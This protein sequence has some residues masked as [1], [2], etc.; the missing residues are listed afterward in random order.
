MS[1]RGRYLIDR[2]KAF[3][4]PTL[5]LP[6]PPYNKEEYWEGVYHKF[7]PQDFFEW[8]NV[9]LIQDLLEFQY[10]LEAHSIH[11]TTI[12]TNTNDTI[13]TTTFAEVINVLPKEMGKKIVLLGCGNSRFGEEMAH[14]GWLGPILQLDI[15]GKAVHMLQERWQQSTSIANSQG[16]IM[17]FI[18]DDATELSAIASDSIDAVFDKG[19]LDALFCCSGVSIKD[20]VDPNIDAIMKSVHRVLKPNGGIFAFLSFSQPQFLLHHTIARQSTNNPNNNKDRSHP[21]LWKDIQIRKLPTIF[22]YRY[23]KNHPPKL[24]LSENLMTRKQTKNYTSKHTN[25]TPKQRR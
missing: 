15:S 17:E 2:M 12:P 1:L 13:S 16:T 22:L 4:S 19:L 11:N 25:H 3:V 5:K 8:G 21:L 20:Q 14:Q 9:S 24:N 18:Q 23:E 10:S 6:C 7:S